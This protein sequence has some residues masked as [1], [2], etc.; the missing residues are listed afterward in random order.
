VFIFVKSDVVLVGSALLARGWTHPLSAPST[1]GWG[2]GPGRST[3]L[4][5][6]V[7]LKQHP[8]DGVVILQPPLKADLSP[9][10]HD[11]RRYGYLHFLK[12]GRRKQ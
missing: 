2:R 12:Y 7:M 1:A 4:N 8:G 11:F 5:V 3:G 10:L 9:L 6:F